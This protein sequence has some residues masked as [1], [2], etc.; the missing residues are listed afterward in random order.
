M[1]NESIMNNDEGRHNGSM[2]QDRRGDFPMS[3]L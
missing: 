2:G 1:E 3:S